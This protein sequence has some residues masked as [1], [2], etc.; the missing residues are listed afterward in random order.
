MGF[1]R[2]SMTVLW[3]KGLCRLAPLLKKRT[4]HRNHWLREWSPSLYFKKTKIVGSPPYFISYATC[5][6]KQHFLLCFRSCDRCWHWSRSVASSGRGQ[7][8]P[9]A[10]GRLRWHTAS[11]K[12]M[13]SRSRLLEEFMF[14]VL[15]PRLSPTWEIILVILLLN[16]LEVP[17]SEFLQKSH[18]VGWRKRSIVLWM[19]L[20][21][22]AEGPNSL[23]IFK[24]LRSEHQ[25][26]TRKT[27]M[28][29]SLLGKHGKHFLVV[30]WSPKFRSQFFSGTFWK[31][32]EYFLSCH[33]AGG[34][35][36][37]THI[38]TSFLTYLSKV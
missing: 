7:A 21:L 17:R 28:Y 19:L 27:S 12:F 4:R 8:S 10:Q 26:N 18:H 16:H 14:N 1:A 35:R 32:W 3:A 15:W 6:V 23:W 11:T 5:E 20:G 36:K 31:V 29:H 34:W 25:K 2:K 13:S 33:S 9:A 30:L 38:L 37:T 24:I 22:E